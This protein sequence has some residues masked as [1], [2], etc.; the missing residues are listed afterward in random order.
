MNDIL[1]VEGLTKHFPGFS[2]EHI[3]FAL[4]YGSI[5]GFVGENGAGKTTTI[6]LILGLL[7]RDEGEIELFGSRVG[8]NEGAI[9]RRIGV[10]LDASTFHD[11]LRPQDVGRILRGMYDGWDEDTFLSLVRRFE[12]PMNSKTLKDFSTG[13]KKKLAIAA[14]LSHHPELLILDE[15]TSGLD[16]VIRA[17]ILDILLDFIQDERHGVLLSSHITSDLERIADYIT[18]I[19]KGRLVF[20]TE[21]DALLERYGVV[22]CTAEEAERIGKDGVLGHRRSAFGVELLVDDRLAFARNHPHLLI[23]PA[24]I[25]EIMTFIARG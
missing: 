19:H 16:P 13:M 3:S 11:A 5:M 20:S 6:K 14:A 10:V 18:F 25:E 17:E 15:P 8:G 23:D 2:L 12:L 4:P 1:K 21:K 7:R 22:H 24:D 9:K